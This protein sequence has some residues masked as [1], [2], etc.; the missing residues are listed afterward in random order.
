MLAGM[1]VFA[2][3]LEVR[4]KAV[5]MLR[6]GIGNAEV[7]RALGIPVGTIGAWKHEDRRRAGTLPGRRASTCPRCNP[8]EL[9]LNRRSYA[10]L[11]GLYLGDGYIGGGAAMRKKGVQFLNICCADA[12]PGL[13]DECESAIRRVMPANS[14]CR[15]Q[16]PGMHE[17]KAYSKHW[18]CLFP[19]H[20]PGRKHER[21]I[22]L[23]AWQREI[24]AE[25]PEQFIRGLIHSDGCRVCNVAVR[26][27]GDK[28]TRYYYSRYHFTNESPHI[29]D[30]FTQALDRVGV[31]WR[32]NRR[33]CVSIA[34]RKSV[35]RLDSFVGPKY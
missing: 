5:A 20:G 10:Y 17:V 1:P 27:R 15:V 3:S 9:P 29:R 25:F 22:V 30:L 19:Q 32:Y 6:S 2:H 31:E 21:A 4:T 13:M 8:D 34:R 18:L 28:T 24:V 14:V 16:K 7:A 12:W 35:R 11:L 33:N 23:E 26:T